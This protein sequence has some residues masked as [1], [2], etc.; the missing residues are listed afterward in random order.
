M[1]SWLSTQCL[2]RS[3]SNSSVPELK[4]SVVDHKTA[5]I[6]KPILCGSID[7]ISVHLSWHCSGNSK[8][9]HLLCWSCPTACVRQRFSFILHASS[10]IIF[11]L[12]FGPF[13]RTIQSLP[14][15]CHDMQ[16]SQHPHSR[17]YPVVRW[18]L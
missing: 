7:H 18:H 4:G 11:H 1:C 14:S 17:I 5:P 15:Q 6:Q 16:V 8:Q 9:V 10:T 2:S 12:T 13:S 3:Q